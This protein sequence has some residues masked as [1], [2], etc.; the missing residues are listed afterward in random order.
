[1]TSVLNSKCPRRLNICWASCPLLL[2]TAGCAEAMC[3]AGE[4]CCWHSIPRKEKDENVAMSCSA[5]FY[6]QQ[7]NGSFSG[8][9]SSL[10]LSKGAF[11]V[12]I[13]LGFGT[14]GSSYL[15]EKNPQICSNLI[16]RN[17]TNSNTINMQ[18]WQT[19]DTGASEVATQH[20]WGESLVQLLWWSP[21]TQSHQW[22]PAPPGCAS[23][24]VGTSMS[25]PA[26][27]RSDCALL[28]QCHRFILHSVKKSFLRR[29]YFSAVTIIC[30]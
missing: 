21:V 19:S 10:A 22:V 13:Y 16:T 15:K 17:D 24:A 14:G 6:S 29:F 9:I 28:C 3:W 12:L 18:L 1:M 23:A 26:S 25:P 2:Q 4:K 8:L 11:S 5:V 7:T 27:P 20:S 30:F